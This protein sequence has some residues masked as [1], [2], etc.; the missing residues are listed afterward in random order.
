MANVCGKIPQDAK[1]IIMKKCRVVNICAFKSPGVEIS[2]DTICRQV[3]K[4]NE[5]WC[6]CGIVFNL[7][8]IKQLA[9]VVTNPDDY[10]FK[11]NEIDSS[12]EFLNNMTHYPTAQKLY[13]LKPCCSDNRHVVLH[14]VDGTEFGKSHEQGV[15]KGDD[16]LNKYFI[17]MVARVPFEEILAHELGHCL[18]LEHEKDENNVM[19]AKRPGLE[20]TT[21]QCAIIHESPLIQ[22]EFYPVGFTKEFPKLFEVEILN[23]D[24]YWVD[25]GKGNNDLE[26]RWDFTINTGMS[27]SGFQ[28]SWENHKVESGSK[29]H[30]GIRTVASIVNDLDV[31]MVRM[32]GIEFDSWPDPDDSLPTFPTRVFDKSTVWGSNPGAFS[33]GIL[34]NSQIKCEIFYLIK[35]VAPQVHP[36]PNFCKDAIIE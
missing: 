30:I 15:G 4:A 22:Q 6:K 33:T 1:D 21:T 3:Q 28:Q 14:Y 10:R 7:T 29:Y 36:I 2:D 26:L 8:K 24:V 16:N 32:S 18:G 11:L 19:F 23:M 34:G 5:I 9:D 31:L 35:E 27:G 25:D 13:D 17:M 20:V 12:N